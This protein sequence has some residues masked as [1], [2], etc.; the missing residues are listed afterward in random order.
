M[1]LTYENRRNMTASEWQEVARLVPVLCGMARLGNPVL[2]K[3]DGYRDV[4]GRYTVVVHG[5]VDESPLFRCDAS[6]LPALLA[7]AVHVCG[8]SD[9]PV[10][11]AGA[12]SE[13]A[14]AFRLADAAVHDESFLA[15]YAQQS[16]HR[17]YFNLVYGESS[18]LKP[19]CL[20]LCVDGDDL[21]SML[22]GIYAKTSF[23]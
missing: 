16:S 11:E 22:P 12:A 6:S 9:A 1:S 20:K 14:D 13:L 7:E 3:I 4:S 10:E 19:S 18:G 17:P 8:L 5:G 21:A 23:P 2:I 15:V